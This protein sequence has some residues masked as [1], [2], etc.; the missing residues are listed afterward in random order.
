MRNSLSLLAMVGISASLSLP[1][2]ADQL[3]L[4]ISGTITD[5]NASAET[6]AAGAHSARATIVYDTSVE[7]EL[8]RYTHLPINTIEYQ[9]TILS[10]TYE[11][12]DVHGDAIDISGTTAFDPTSAYLVEENLY[13]LEYPETD[14][15]QQRAFFQA[16]FVPNN[17]SDYEEQM[18]IYFGQLTDAD[19]IDT[20]IAPHRII[21]D[22]PN[23][24]VTLFTTFSSNEQ[25]QLL[26]RIASPTLTYSLSDDDNDG[27]ANG[28][29]LCTATAADTTVVI[30][31]IDSGVTNH[32]DTDG[33]AISDHFAACEAEQQSVPFLAYRGP[34]MCETGVMYDAYRNGLIDYMELRQLRATLY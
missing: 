11:F 33:C 13:R 19:F 7:P 32:V 18:R 27:V 3:E 8:G 29:D 6:Y 23:R 2:A 1:A 24:F 14:V 9:N 4:T 12:F 16:Y 34:T 26:F 31:G 20:S 22:E 15:H 28:A 17:T 5:T 30:D 21:T 10:I 25:H